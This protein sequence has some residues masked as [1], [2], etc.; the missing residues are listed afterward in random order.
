[1]EKRERG[2]VR[3]LLSGLADL[4]PDGG[5][6]RE[7]QAPDIPGD[8]DADSEYRRAVLRAKSQMTSGGQGTT[9]YESVH[10]DPPRD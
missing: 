6:G 1:M 3:R 8:R 5:V 4:L 9:S 10:R 2:L 7:D